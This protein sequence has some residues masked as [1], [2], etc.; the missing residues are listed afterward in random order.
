[1]DLNKNF[2]F[3]PIFLKNTHSQK[4]DKLYFV[5][6]NFLLL[7]FRLTLYYSEKSQK[8]DFF[9]HKNTLNNIHI[10][11]FFYIYNQ[12]LKHKN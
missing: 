3:L 7:N 4:T 6:C 11:I 9:L 10:F 2:I 8:S 1:M 12:T 5:V